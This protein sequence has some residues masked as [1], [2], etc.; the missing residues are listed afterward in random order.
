MNSV[1]VC[2]SS[3]IAFCPLVCC[4][5]HISCRDS[6]S[7]FVAGMP[8]SYLELSP[9]N[10]FRPPLYKRPVFY[11]PLAIFLFLLLV[12]GIYVLS[13]VT[14]SISQAATFDLSSSN[15]WNRPA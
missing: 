9:L 7:V 13:V 14:V 5:F 4:K 10:R 6:R 2:A 12:A 3:A 11:V 8:V 15:R 1:N